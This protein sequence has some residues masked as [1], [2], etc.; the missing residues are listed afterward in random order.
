MIFLKLETLLGGKCVVFE[1]TDRTEMIGGSMVIF[2][3]YSKVLLK[4]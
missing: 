4:A 3:S 1:P 2:A